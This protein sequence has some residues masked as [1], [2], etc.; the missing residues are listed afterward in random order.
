M[1]PPVIEPPDDDDPP[2]F[3]YQDPSPLDSKTIRVINEWV[4]TIFS[5]IV[6]AVIALVLVTCAFVFVGE[7]LRAVF[8]E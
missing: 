2:H 6:F 1:K 4:P 3:W 5:L 7:G 8:G